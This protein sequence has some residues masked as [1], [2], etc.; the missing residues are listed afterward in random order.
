ML[1]SSSTM[2]AAQHAVSYEV[3]RS[4]YADVVQVC[5]L[6]SILLYTYYFDVVVV[7]VD[8]IRSTTFYK[9]RRCI[10]STLLFSTLTP[11]KVQ[12]STNANVVQVCPLAH[13]CTRIVSTLLLST[14]TYAITTW[15]FRQGTAKVSF[16]QTIATGIEER[17]DEWQ[18]HDDISW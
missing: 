12:C 5:A 7:Y 14:L 18:R 2:V 6:L 8:V 9:C 16:A 3:R 1:A 17:R 10:I 4:T 13:C 15:R 11:Y